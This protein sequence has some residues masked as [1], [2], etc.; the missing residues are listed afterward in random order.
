[1]TPASPVRTLAWKLGASIAAIALSLLLAFVAEWFF[2]G[3]LVGLVLSIL[4]W[5]ELGQALRDAPDNG[6]VARALGLLMA[7]PQALFGLTSLLVGLGIAAWVLYNTFVERLPHYSGG[8]LT[9]GIAPV[10]VMAG[11]GWLVMAFRRRGGTR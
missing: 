11:L 8:F 3:A 5:V 1:M 10:L 7:L 9:L 4:Y 6:R 2:L